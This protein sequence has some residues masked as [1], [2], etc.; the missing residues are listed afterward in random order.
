METQLVLWVQ[1]YY[2]C[3]GYACPCACTNFMHQQASPNRWHFRYRERTSSKTSWK[4]KM[5]EPLDRMRRGNGRGV[6]LPCFLVSCLWELLSFMISPWK[7]FFSSFKRFYREKL[8]QLVDYNS[9]ISRKS[10]CPTISPF[11]SLPD[12]PSSRNWNK[13]Q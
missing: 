6:V 9:F 3:V 12:A 4:E 1:Y 2:Y 11:I 5:V 13:K 8:S 7:P 10:I